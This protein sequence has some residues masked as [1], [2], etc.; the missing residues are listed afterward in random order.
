MCILS[1]ASLSGCV[2]VCLSAESEED[3]GQCV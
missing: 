1:L 3:A 2:C